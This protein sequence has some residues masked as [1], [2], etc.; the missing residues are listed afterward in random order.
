MAEDEDF[1]DSLFDLES[2][3]GYQTKDLQLE[4][5]LGVLETCRYTD[6][7]VRTGTFDDGSGQYATMVP[8]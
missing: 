5:V 8:T 7:L 2:S 4:Y 1:V 3:N 6:R